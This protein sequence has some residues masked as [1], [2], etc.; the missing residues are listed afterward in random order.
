MSVE[1]Q[2]PATENDHYHACPLCAG[3]ALRSLAAADRLDVHWQLLCCASCG[4]HLTDPRPSEE[5]LD[6][7]YSGR[8]HANLHTPGASERIFGPK[9]HGYADWL[10]SVLPGGRVLDLGCS[11]GLLV[12]LLC[13][14]GYQAEGLEINS[15]TAAWGRAHYGVTIH[16][17]LFEDPSYD[18]EP[19]DAILMTDVLEHMRDPLA[20][21]RLVVQRLRP[22]GIVLVTFPDIHSVESRYWRLLARLTG[23]SWLWGHW[24]VPEHI[25][26]FTPTTARRLFSAAGL[27]VARYRRSHLDRQAGDNQVSALIR[28][29]KLPVGPLGWPP[30]AGWFGTQLEF[31]LRKPGVAQPRT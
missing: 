3:T 30:L 15:R 13:D 14:R 9:Y 28:L 7:L 25:F 8:Y 2:I 19:F 5:F 12:R 31:L 22:G 1:S 21:L 6:R 20:F 18:T 24:H 11:T 4:L 16:D 27:E 26:E 23:R 17:H 10:K 29:L